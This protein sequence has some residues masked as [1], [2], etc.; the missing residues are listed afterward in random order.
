VAD[1]IAA[2]PARYPLHSTGGLPIDFDRRYARETMSAMDVL[3]AALAQVPPRSELAGEP[4]RASVCIVVAGPLASPS[5]C[6]IRRARW[7]R[8]PWSEHIALPG[9][10]NT[11]DEDARDTALRELQ[12]EVG[13]VVP[14]DVELTR[15]PELHV[16]L[17]GRERLLVLDAFVCFLGEALPPLSAGPELDL[18]FWVPIAALWDLASATSN[19]LDDGETLVYPAIEIPQ[20]LIFGITLRTLIL[21]SDQLGIPIPM[22]EEI[23][24]L[25]GAKP[26]R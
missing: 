11:G 7:E 5:V 17:A 12:E 15:L 21:L 3:R 10:R 9:G 14:P 25:R 16:R 2:L 6:M 24:R 23:P 13:L 1:E 22:L 8:D 19:V 4:M 20:G 26:I 18:A